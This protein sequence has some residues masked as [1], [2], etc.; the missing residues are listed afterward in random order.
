MSKRWGRALAR[1]IKTITLVQRP[2]R[3]AAS[4]LRVA[5][6]MVQ[7][8]WVETKSGRILFVSPEPRALE[9]PRD[10]LARE[11]ETLAWIDGFRTPCIY[12]DIGANVG[13]YALYA[14]LRP[15]VTTYAFEP[16][17]SNYLA[18]CRNIYE[19]GMEANVRAYCIALDDRVGLASLDMDDLS[20]GS[21][22]HSFGDEPIVARPTHKT[23]FRQPAIGFSIDA[24]R[25]T[26][27]LAT[28]HYLKL[29][30][31]G[32]EEK[33]LAGARTTL[34]DPALRSIMIEVD[35]KGPRTQDLF[36]TLKQYGLTFTRWGVDHGLGAINA[37]F[38][39][40][41]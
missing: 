24:F 20:A 16:S 18:M 13:S 4:R 19:N 41:G 31:D 17:P 7:R 26:F 12:W 40:Q 5:E 11:P 39:R 2:W 22:G 8:H 10:F 21:F 38:N 34:A 35:R 28:P 32:N 23:I 29:D 14:G 15:D 1:G 33:V 9:Y 25:T 27:G 6:A 3:R 37:E 36:D 30:I